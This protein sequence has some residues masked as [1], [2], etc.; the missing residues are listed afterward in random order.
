V[1]ARAGRCHPQP[2]AER[3][4]AAACRSGQEDIKRV[5]ESIVEAAKGSIEAT[6]MPTPAARPAAAVTTPPVSSPP[7]E[8]AKE[9][10]AAEDESQDEEQ[11]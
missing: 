8:E 4:R 7:A 1:G 2:G 11:P 9:P 6:R 10:A 5:A 3:H